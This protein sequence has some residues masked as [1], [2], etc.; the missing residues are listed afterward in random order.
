MKACLINPTKTRIPGSNFISKVIDVGIPMGILQIASVLEKNNYKVDII[1][2]LVD[3]NPIVQNLTENKIRY[4]MTDEELI[5]KIKEIKPDLIGISG[6]FTAQSENV[7]LTA[8]AIKKEFPNIPIAVG[9]A[10]ITCR[11]DDFLKNCKSIDIAVLGEG[12]YIVL[13]LMK[14]LDNKLKLKDI[15]GIVYREGDKLVTNPRRKFIKNMDEL[16]LPAYHLVDMEKYFKLPEKGIYFHRRSKLRSAFIISSRSCPFD[17]CFC[18]SHT[19]MGRGFRAHSAEYVLEHIKL[20]VEKYKVEQIYFEDDNFTFD[21]QRCEK[22]LDKLIEKNYNLTIIAPNGVRADRL[23]ENLILKFKKVGCP[24]LIVAPESGSPRVL[25]KVIHKRFDLNT[26]L[27]VAEICK[28]VGMPLR[29]FFVIGFPGETKE[30]IKMTYNFALK[31]IRKYD[32]DVGGLM[33]A[34]PLY[35]TEL[36]EIA[37]KNNYLTQEI[38][39]ENLSKSLAEGGLIETPD[40]N[41]DYLR[42]INRKFT[43]KAYLHMVYKRL[44]HPKN[45]INRVIEEPYMIKTMLY[46]LI[47][48]HDI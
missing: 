17:C 12:E 15:K 31:L 7:I 37:K 4:G 28:K 10:D 18:A 20:L 44:K 16:P 46:K 8:D 1:D 26:V 33:F 32:V 41:A 11:P 22:I 25:E 14:Y 2:Y 38:T 47:K 29:A 35:G 43:R 34:T 30:D 42:K 40:F 5:N 3:G 9:G 48:G 39:P 23:D 45:L 19:I 36:Y 13:D 27:N 6:L 21:K 24:F